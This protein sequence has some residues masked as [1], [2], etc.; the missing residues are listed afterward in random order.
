MFKIYTDVRNAP[1]IGDR[2]LKYRNLTGSPAYVGIENKDGSNS[3]SIEYQ[4]SNDDTT[5]S[6]LV[7]TPKT[8]NPGAIDGQ[9]VVSSSV[10]IALFAHGNVSLNLIV[11]RPQSGEPLEIQ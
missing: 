11:V 6:T 1:G 9:I 10:Y 8:I 3:A 5:W 2:I 4:E 7:G